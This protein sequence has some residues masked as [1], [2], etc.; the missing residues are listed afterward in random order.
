MVQPRIGQEVYAEDVSLGR[1][2]HLIASLRQRTVT[3][4]VVRGTLPDPDRAGVRT[5]PGDGPWVERQVIIPIEAVKE[6]TAGAL[7]LAISAAEVE[8]LPDFD[9]DEF[10]RPDPGWQPLPPYT[11]DDILL[12]RDEPGVARSS[13]RQGESAG[14]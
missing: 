10:V 1:V 7:V 13:E 3:A 2:E 9:P 6:E 4:L 5:L 14:K 12:I 8:R 11:P